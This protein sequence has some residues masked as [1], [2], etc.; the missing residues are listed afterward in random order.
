[1]TYNTT[2]I[3]VPPSKAANYDKTCAR[4]SYGQLMDR[5]SLFAS[6]VPTLLIP[7]STGDVD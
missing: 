4:R 1:M 7:N 2:S 6:R 3:K 5:P